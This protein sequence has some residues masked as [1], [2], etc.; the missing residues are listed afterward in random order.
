[1]IGPATPWIILA[2]A[3]ALG[4]AGTGGYIKGHSDATTSCDAETY[5]SLAE[6][7]G[8]ALLASQ[9]RLATVN[10]AAAGDARRAL[11]NARRLTELQE[12]I[13]AIPE[14]ADDCLPQPSAGRL[15]NIR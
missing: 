15:R 13:D 3:L 7:R 8:A 4:A 6:A 1:M 10:E 5:R 9:A 14:N 11:E 2:V 12:A